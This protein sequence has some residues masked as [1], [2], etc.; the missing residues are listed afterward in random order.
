MTQSPAQN[1][2]PVRE[3]F[4]KRK[5]RGLVFPLPMLGV[6]HAIKRRISS[7]HEHPLKSIRAAFVVA[8]GVTLRGMA[9]ESL[10]V[11]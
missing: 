3:R 8:P 5:S 7:I 4:R 2:A 10:L 11:V 6:D 9:F 1:S